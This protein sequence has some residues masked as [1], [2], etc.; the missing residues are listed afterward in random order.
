MEL[1]NYRNVFL[2]GLL[3]AA[4]SFGADTG[5]LNLV[6]PDAKVVAGV[7]VTR[8]KASSLGQ[9]FMQN[10]NLH[11]DELGKFT[12][13][14]GFDPRRDLS[15]VVMASVD[16]NTSGKN[17][18][19]LVRGNFDA[20]RIKTFLAQNGLTA[21][22][23]VQG[24][25]LFSKKGDSNGI[26]FFDGGLAAAGDAGAVKAAIARRGGGATM[27]AALFAKIQD[28]SRDND[29][30]MVTSVPVSQFAGKMPGG[31]PE[32][33]GGMM[34]GDM[35]GSVEQAAMGVKFAATMLNVTLEAA[36]RSEKDATAMADV[37]R[38]LSGMVQMN[39]DKS[40]VAGL[41]SALDSM[42]LTTNAKNVRMTMSVPQAEIE[43]MMKSDRAKPA[44]NK[45]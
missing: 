17:A 11:D 9:L 8:A 45:I 25:D 12:S 14:T 18:L 26:A 40:E 7:D 13:L 42:K 1:M 34:K 30:W 2:S 43:K 32:Q 39:R 22:Q 10:M 6:M 38:F 31:T 23:S 20:A 37:A 4:A 5:L 28:M 21:V 44:T 16:T 41:A 35:F 33:I 29:I 19:M 3:L 36:V 15:E 24:V 27:P